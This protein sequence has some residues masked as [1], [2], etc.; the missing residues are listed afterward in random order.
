MDLGNGTA[1]GMAGSVIV[2]P[3]STGSATLQSITVQPANPT[4]AAGS[5]DGFT[6]TGNFSDNSTQ[7]LTSQVT[8]ASSNAGVATITTSGMATGVGPGTSTITA[9]LNGISGSTTLTVGS[10]STQGTAPQFLNEMR[11]VAG[12]GAH[13]KVIGFN[14]FFTPNNALNSTVAQDMSHY[15]VTQP[16]KKKNGPPAHIVVNMAM[17]NPNNNSV[18]LMLGKFTAN[19]P[20]TAAVTGL[21]GANGLAV[22][23][24]TTK[25]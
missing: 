18:M 9:T 7:N 21:T 2:M 23:N 11:M 10:S 14:L 6:A 24:F 13:K 3:S 25:L 16:G 17:Y 5:N 15:S 1:S 8:W 22:P 19:K 12:K 4:I 20:L